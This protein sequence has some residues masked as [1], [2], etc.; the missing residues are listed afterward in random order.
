MTGKYPFYVGQDLKL[1]GGLN[2]RAPRVPTEGARRE[3]IADIQICAP[4]QEHHVPFGMA[5]RKQDARAS[6]VVVALA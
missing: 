3:M 5:G 4:P 6:D 2:L 1:P